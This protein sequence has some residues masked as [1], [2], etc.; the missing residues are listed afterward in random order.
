[1]KER[2]GSTRL[3]SARC[4]AAVLLSL[5]AA[6]GVILVG[7]AIWLAAA[8]ATAQ[9]IDARVTSVYVDP[10]NSDH[11]ADYEFSADGHTCQSS[12]VA[13]AFGRPEPGLRVRVYLVSA[14]G[15][16]ATTDRVGEVMTAF[17]MAWFGGWW[18]FVFLA[19]IPALLRPSAA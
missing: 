11:Y 2:L 4:L 8:D 15:C 17:L 16:I 7:G 6:P 12:D 13:T 3:A 5:M 1:M 10:G 14:E 9:P 18:T 19:N